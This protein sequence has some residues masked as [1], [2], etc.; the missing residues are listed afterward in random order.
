MRHKDALRFPGV[1]HSPQP[2][3]NFPN[4]LDKA[5][6]PSRSSNSLSAC[7][8]RTRYFC[9]S[10]IPR[11]GSRARPSIVPSHQTDLCLLDATLSLNAFLLPGDRGLTDLPAMLLTMLQA[12][13]KPCPFLLTG[14]DGIRWEVASSLPVSMF[15]GPMARLASNEDLTCIMYR[16]R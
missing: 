15:T 9:S 12:A 14:S 13:S 4:P 8:K 2:S 3:S 6:W 5:P 10:K 16:K 1:D 7:A 11:Q